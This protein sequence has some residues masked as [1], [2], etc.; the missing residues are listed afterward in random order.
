MK[1]A[2]GGL[3]IEK[4]SRF[5]NLS[6]YCRTLNALHDLSDLLLLFKQILISL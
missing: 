2:L 5:K 6:F 1:A 4:Y 3:H